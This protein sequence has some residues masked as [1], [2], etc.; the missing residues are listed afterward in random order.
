MTD[1]T[2]LTPEAIVDM[3]MTKIGTPLGLDARFRPTMQTLAATVLDIGATESAATLTQ[4]ISAWLVVTS[5]LVSEVM[6]TIPNL[7]GADFVIAYDRAVHA[8]D[9]DPALAEHMVEDVIHALTYYG[10]DPG[11]VEP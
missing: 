2:G 7:T 8:A 4:Q 1:K 6:K 9:I 10:V 11:P 3:T 5:Y